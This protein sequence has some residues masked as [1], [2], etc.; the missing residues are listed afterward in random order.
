MA[1]DIVLILVTF[2]AV[3]AGTVSNPSRR[4]KAAIISLAIVTSIGTA[5]KTLDSASK[6]EINARLIG[7]LVQ[8]SNPPEYF[9]H[10][11][12]RA[13]GPL[14]EETGQYISGQTV[15][16]ETSERIITLSDFG[17]DEYVGGILFLSHKQMNPIFYEYA[18]DGDLTKPV[19][20]H[21]DTQWTDCNE[22]WT[23]CILEL[24]GISKHAMEVAPIDVYETTAAMK[25][26]LTFSLE[27]SELFGGR[28]IRIELDRK[29]IESLYGLAP[30]ERGA[31]I[32]DAG[33]EA[34]IDQL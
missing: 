18:V 13:L 22:H 5:V 29:F 20:D 28:P 3:V 4:V 10:E 19:A 6:N 9:T 33:H 24:R 30:S 2:M 16:E 32:L 12:V 25:A 26:D 23:D 34:I 15:Y 27:S 31:K 17:N 8:A 21:L 7:T 1:I 14:F 11:L